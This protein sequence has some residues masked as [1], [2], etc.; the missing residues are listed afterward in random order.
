M[1]NAREYFDRNR[2]L[3]ISQELNVTR[4][5][6]EQIP[7]TVKVA[8][9]FEGGSRY[10]KVYI[11]H[12]QDPDR[13]IEAV[14]ERA[15][16]L[17]A[18]QD[19]PK[20]WAGQHGTEESIDGE[21]L[22]FSGRILLYTP[23]VIDKARWDLVQKRLQHKGLALVVRDGRY[24]DA[25]SSSERPL[26]FISHDSR[27]KEP[28]VRELANQLAAMACPVWYDEF[29]LIPGQSLRVSI[30]TG[31]KRSTKCIVVLSKNFFA[32]P[33]WSRR[34]FDMI[35]TREI[36]EGKRIMIPV[37][38]NVT[39]NDVFDYSP[40]LLDTFGIQASIGVEQVAGKI[41]A[42]INYD[43]NDRAIE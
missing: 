2:F 8:F 14:A 13:L 22:K 23:S 24:V 41:V 1:P 18:G 38:L 40:I 11:P 36:L 7:V 10:L 6:G 35:Y 29:S 30:E 26:A 25:R 27:D 42:A 3:E 20:V 33:G 5:D 19:G 43:P 31:L 28:F 37:W 4:A 34:E 16:S 32:N 39:K 15:E 17:V 12:A 21:T 9:D